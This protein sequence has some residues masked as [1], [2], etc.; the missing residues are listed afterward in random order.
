MLVPLTDRSNPYAGMML[1]LIADQKARAHDAKAQR[2]GTAR[3][4]RK[5]RA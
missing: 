5:R 1:R 2:R 4:A 3:A